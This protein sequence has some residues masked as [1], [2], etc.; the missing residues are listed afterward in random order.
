MFE[1]GHRYRR[2]DLHAQY[3]GQ[4]Q[5][6]I[7]T[8]VSHPLIMLV[9]GESGTA[10]GYTDGWEDD[11]TFR[12]FGEGQVGDMSFV[13]GNRAVL[14]HAAAGR[15]LHL[16]EDLNDAHLRYVGE[17]TCAGFDWVDKVPDRNGAARRAIAFRLIPVD[18]ADPDDDPPP[19]GAPADDT[20]WTRPL[21]ELR[22]A[23]VEAPQDVDPH[24]ARRRVWVRSRALR[25]YVLR[26]ADGTCEACGQPAPFTT[27]AGR[28]YLEAHHTRR[29]SDGG[30]DDPRWVIAV[31]PN[32]HCRVHHGDDGDAFNEK[33]K[34]TLGTLEPTA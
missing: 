7:S 20:L 26:R 24:E 12:Y 9:T 10:Y 1:V 15:E 27:S 3:G 30:P 23:A 8:P 32:C 6:G 31:C 16:F 17:M 22:Q 21:A 28:P 11:G 25:I 33:L 5:G 14:E 2:R 34:A 4:R 18:A 13:R 29:I 19:P